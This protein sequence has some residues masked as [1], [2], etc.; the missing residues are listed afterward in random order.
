MSDASWDQA[1]VRELRGRMSGAVFGRE[2][3]GYEGARE[4]FNSAIEV[5]PKLIAQ[6]RTPEEVA[7]G[8]AFAQRNALELAVRSGGHSVAGASLS[9]DGIVLDMRPMDEVAV[10]PDA[11]T[12]TVGGGA[13]WRDVDRATQ[14]H[15]L[16]TTGGRVSTTGVAG[17]AL[18]GG[19]GWLERKLGLS[20]DNLLSVDLI[21]ADGSPVTASEHNNPDLFWALHGG[22]GNFGVATSLTFRLHPLPEFS[23]A[24]LL[25]APEDG[26]EVVRAFRELM[27]EGPEEL[28]GGVIYLTAP[29]ED[30]VPE[31]LVGSL[32]CAVLITCMGPETDLREQIADLLALRPAGSLIM[33]LP[34]AE[35]QC[36]LDD[37]PG[38]RNYWSAEYLHGMPDQAVQLF[39]D[40]AH[41]MVIPSPSQHVLLPW[42]GAV[43]RGE[44]VWPM[45]N[46]SAPWVVHP[47]GLWED[48]ADDGRA[49]HWAHAV[50]EGMRPYS[51]GATYLNFIGDEGE[52]R[53]VAGF[54]EENYQALTRVKAQYD[55]DNIFHRWHN[56]RP[57]RPVG[58]SG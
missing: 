27:T 52:R 9:A 13:L 18:G 43:A 51:T 38:Y 26:P 21:I 33:E 3:A 25:W 37:P 55:P 36:M 54:G 11:R 58:L 40:L 39:C 49:R 46:R 48:S 1:L 42:G 56:V 29:Q 14:P 31:R 41:E 47:L 53:V 34:Y 19:S 12:V 23:A 50:R 45:S 2:D 20:C 10:D 15:G 32:A 16:A 6:C 8:V 24:L 57:A 5:E 7:I 22:G 28:G 4:L 35:L 44:G 17:L 30:F